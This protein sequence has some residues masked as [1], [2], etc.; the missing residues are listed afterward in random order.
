MISWIDA[1]LISL[2]V[3]AVTRTKKNLT[4]IF[5]CEECGEMDEY[6]G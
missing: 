5:D 3:K 2:I 6:V 4:K 1:N